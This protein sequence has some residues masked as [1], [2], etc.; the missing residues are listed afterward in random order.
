M[1]ELPLQPRKPSHLRTSLALSSLAGVLAK[2]SCSHVLH[3][4]NTT[5]RSSPFQSPPAYQELSSKT[6][7]CCRTGLGPNEVDIKDLSSL[8]NASEKDSAT[9]AIQKY[10]EPPKKQVSQGQMIAMSILCLHGTA[11]RSLDFKIGASAVAEHLSRR[12]T[13]PVMQTQLCPCKMLQL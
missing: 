11:L 8:P 5:L 6:L 13:Q 10:A 12:T 1:Q 3:I 7:G 4:S 2:A 9:P